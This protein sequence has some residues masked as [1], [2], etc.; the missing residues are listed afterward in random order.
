VVIGEGE[1]VWPQI[2]RDLQ[3]G[4]LQKFYNAKA[5]GPFDFQHAPMPRYDLLTP[6]RYPR[7][8][9]QT[10]RGCPWSCEFCAASIRL[11]PQFR[12]KPIALVIQEVRALKSLYRRPFI[13]FADDNTFVDKRHGRALM[14]A[15]A[16]EQVRW[17]TETDV[18][19]ADDPT[20]LQLMRDAGCHQILIGFE[21]P[22][23]GSLQGME[24]NANWKA[25]RTD[26]YL[27][28]IETIQRHGITVN[29]C[30][31]MG[32]DG[33]GP[34]S[35]QHV[36][37]FVKQSGLYD[38]QITYLT[39]FPGTPLWA[40]LSEAGRIISHE[41]LEKCS[42]FDINFHPTHQTVEQLRTGFHALTAQLYEPTFVAARTRAFRRQ[43]KGHTLQT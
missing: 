43:R 36:F 21:S 16:P 13:E 40:R 3:A 11:T 27:R 37:D 15:L 12:T 18:S 6:E 31:I 29:G 33:D 23:P 2:L 34:E 17:F 28:A 4:H 7:F 35:F 20:L 25:K 39:P 19:V 5:R 22:L 41:A 9:L 30:F 14:R 8:T 24:L 1:V 42:L 26:R 10:Q 32:L 38:V